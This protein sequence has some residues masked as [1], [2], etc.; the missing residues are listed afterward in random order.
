M[1]GPMPPA[2]GGI[3]NPEEIGK[4]IDKLPPG[5]ETMAQLLQN[6]VVAGLASV[7]LTAVTGTPISPQQ[8]M[9]GAQ[10][11]EKAIKMRR[12]Q[13]E[14]NQEGVSNGPRPGN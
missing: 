4:Q 6:P 1:T 5:S 7:V 14:E 12:E 3:P 10:I 2:G 9:M 11:G 13:K 8:V